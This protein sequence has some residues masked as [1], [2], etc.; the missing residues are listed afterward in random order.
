MELGSI[1]YRVLVRAVRSLCGSMISFLAVV[2]VKAHSLLLRRF[3]ELVF[4]SGAEK[5]RGGIT[6]ILIPDQK[7]LLYW[8]PIPLQKIIALGFS[9]MLVSVS[10]PK[11]FPVRVSF[12]FSLG[13]FFCF[14]F[15][16]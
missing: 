9:F 11:F 16:A 8:F 4:S 10:T 5:M 14:F 15:S 6:N 3:E 7:S 1:A 13:L 12:F 2:L